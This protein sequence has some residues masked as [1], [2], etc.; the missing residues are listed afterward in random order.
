MYNVIMVLADQHNADLMGCAGH[1]QVITPHLD[2]FASEG[3]RFTSAYT[4]NPI[5]TPSRVSILSGQYCHNHGY[6]GLSGPA[7]TGLNNFLRHFRNH[8]Y[9]TAAL[10]KLHLPE[11][12]R[13]WIADDV[14]YFGDAYETIDGTIGESKYISHLTELGLRDKEDSWHNPWNYGK[15]SITHDAKPSELPYEHTM[16]MWCLQRAIQFMGEQSDKPFCVKLDFQK[17]H[18]PLLPNQQFWDMYPESIELPE[19]F[20]Q[21]P[22][23]RPPHF[24]K[25]FQQFR[26]ASWD[27]AAEGDS[28]EDGARR[29]WRGTLAC[30]TQIDDVF[31]QLLNFL[32]KSGLAKNTIVVY[33]SDHG[34]YH[35]IH[36]IEEKAPGICSEAVC[37]V[38]MLW[39]VPGV[40]A[41]NTVYSSLAENID[42]APTLCSICKL[43]AMDSTDGHDLSTALK[44]SQ[45]PVRNTAVTENVWSKA[46]RWKN[47]RFVHYQESQFDGVNTG[48][49]YDIEKD[50]NET[51]NLYHDTAF[52]GVVHD[53]RKKLLEWIIETQRVTTAMPNKPHSVS[54]DNPLDSE[55]DSPAI[56]KKRHYLMETDN[57]GPNSV[58]PRN[59]TD[60]LEMYL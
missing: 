31:G 36:G 8:G 41:E 57:R 17:P 25:A 37:R 18:H 49:L 3:V 51:K 19:T 43:P 42:I 10:G 20:N 26:D 24:Q 28:F 15:P 59:R 12:P 29:A 32:E 48:E 30:I 14:D 21:D 6:Y 5:C 52:Q 56:A 7:P 35:G 38:P 16:E 34:A 4:Q 2:H 46:I 40:T 22:S 1:S 50:P 45:E 44:G 39:R 58:Q 54:Q 13:N 11:S 53:C 60:Q 9:R 33:G 55:P 47:W 27:F 23:H